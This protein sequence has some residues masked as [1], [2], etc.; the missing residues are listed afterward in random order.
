[1]PPKKSAVGK[2]S[3]KVNNSSSF[4]DLYIS[5][6]NQYKQ[7]YGP[8][9]VILIQVGSFYEMYDLVNN[10]TGETKA[11]VQEVVE[12]LGRYVPPKPT[13]DPEWSHLFWGFPDHA[14]PIY[15]KMLVE[16]NYRVVIFSQINDNLGNVK[17]RELDYIS[18]LGTYVDMDYQNAKKTENDRHIVG[19]FI[20]Y[21]NDNGKPKWYMASSAFNITTGKASSTE[22][23]VTII[24][25]KPVLDMFEPFWSVYQPAEIVVW[26][27]NSCN[28]TE[29]QIKSWFYGYQ[30]IINTYQ[31]SK[32]NLSASSSRGRSELLRRIY[33]PDCSLSIDEYLGLQYYNN[34]LQCLAML[35][36]FVKE[37]MPSYL[38][39]LQDHSFWTPDNELLLGNS[40]LE[41]LS[42]TP[43]GK[44]TECLLHILQKGYTAGGRRYIKERCLKP[45]TDIIE[46]N[47][48][49]DRI[50]E[51]RGMI[52]K[53]FDCMFK[54]IFDIARLHRKFQLCK[55]HAID[56]QQLLSSYQ[57]IVVLLNNM[58]NTLSC[59]EKEHE[60]IDYINKMN[61]HWSI[62]RMQSCGTDHTLAV[63]PFHPWVRGIHTDLDSLE[64]EWT[65]LINRIMEIKLNWE[66]L[67]GEEDCLKLEWKNDNPFTISTTKRR[68]QSL[69]AAC[70]KNNINNVDVKTKGSTSVVSLTTTEIDNININ[71]LSLWKK[72]TTSVSLKWTAEWNEWKP[73]DGLVEWISQLDAEYCFARISEEYGYIR[74]LY[75]ENKDSAGIYIKDMRHP[76]IERVNP[77][78]P[79][80]P[81]TIGLGCLSTEL[82]I[83]LQSGACADLG[84]LLYGVNASGKSSLSKAIGLC[85]ILAQCGIPVPATEMKLSPYQS[86][87][88]RILGNDNLWAGMS[89]FV[90]EMTE[91][92]SILK[93]AG[94]K[95]LVLGDELCSGTETISATA[96]VTAGIQTLTEHKT[97]FIFATHLH[98][99]MDMKE[100]TEIN[101]VKPYHLTVQADTRPG[102]KLI[103]DRQLKFGSGSPMYGL[104]VCRGLDMDSEFLSKAIAI[105]KK[106]ENIPNI[107]KV[108]R[109]NSGVPVQLCEVCGSIDKLETHHI[110][111]QASA[112]KKGYIR[113][114]KH[115]NSVDNLV[116]LCDNCHD[117][118]HS[119][120]LII[121]GWI[122]TSKG[123]EL[124]IKQ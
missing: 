86:L 13:D 8:R 107:N 3:I 106:L 116:V 58:H 122:Q 70:K 63:G 46:L 60:F 25:G 102:G 124:D 43:L 97:Q 51:L 21:Y 83:D 93:S 72:W 10:T 1:M 54:G 38:E 24:D 79:Y 49:Q 87:F 100:I 20:D 61:S 89:S 105:R 80:I 90:V 84:I 110:V 121:N 39:N 56:L 113:N 117:N 99:L 65:K 53:S 33:K 18:S 41:Q 26:Y 31:L 19:I 81:H 29:Q 108:S 75:I 94:P 98:E 22:N 120:K 114:G 50:E 14:L 95:T 45:I 40:A 5:Y 76:I 111:P 118:H 85:V 55:G 17:S 59:P 119:G 78:I 104:E 68:A 92:R 32:D 88:T 74:P 67:I 69:L 71:A 6:Y 109:Y 37:H 91:F 96:I 35:M 48:R 11:N 23:S 7:K 4:D 36:E 64:D 42:M 47:D 34:A 62:E 115:K 82:N 15:E 77:S 103:Y 66:K 101:Q 9:V 28:I 52:S 2:K 57:K 16:G 44:P 12:F 123:R 27:F 112:N 30:G 73:I